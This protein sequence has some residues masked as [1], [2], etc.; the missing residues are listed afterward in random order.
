[1]PYID[2]HFSI[3]SNFKFCILEFEVDFEYLT[4]KN[5]KAESYNCKKPNRYKH[6]LAVFADLFVKIIYTT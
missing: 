3:C 1:M 5:A 2:F 6:S 4:P